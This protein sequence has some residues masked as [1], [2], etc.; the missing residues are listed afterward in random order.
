MPTHMLTVGGEV[1]L[2]MLNLN[3]TLDN[4]VVADEFGVLHIR[5]AATLGGVSKNIKDVLS[6]EPRNTY[7]DN[8][9]E[10]D[11]FVNAND[12][13]IYCFLN[14]EWKQLNN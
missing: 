7:P 5:D 9:K 4:V 8:P 11:I 6:L 13:N 12:H 10:G 2:E 1:K 3:N 14:G